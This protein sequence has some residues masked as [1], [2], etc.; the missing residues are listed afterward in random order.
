MENKPQNVFEKLDKQGEQIEDISQ[1]LEGI[2]IEDLYALAKRT[3][4]YED[5]Q[6]AQ[7]YYNHI[8]LLKPLDWEAPLY[9]SLCN[10]KGSH[11][12]DFWEYGLVQASKVLVSTINY[13]NGLSL[14]LDEKN[15]EMSKCLEIIEDFMIVT[16]NM[17]FKNKDIFDVHIPDFVSRLE[18]FFLNVY[19][20]TLSIELES[21]I[22]FRVIIS[23][24]CLDLIQS[25]KEI[26]PDLTKE[27]YLKL[28]EIANKKY[29]IDYDAIITHQIE[30]SKE[31]SND[32][33]NE[34]MLKGTKLF[35]YKDKVIAKRNFK[36]N[37]IV[38]MIL[39]IISISGMVVSFIGEWYWLF[40]FVFSFVYGLLLITKALTEK[41]TIKCSSLLC[42]N[43][44]KNRLTSDGNVVEDDMFNFMRLI[45][46]IVLYLVL[47]VDV[48]MSII[49]LSSSDQIKLKIPFVIIAALNIISFVISL[50]GVNEHHSRFEGNYSYYYNGKYYK[51]DK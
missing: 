3:W 23:D 24:E 8:S 22:S 27:E 48:F 11:Q 46:F 34:I 49:V 41:K 7:K 14:S 39:T 20:K 5:Y 40:A 35:E 37:F 38:G 17:Y 44:V 29:D 31:M 45:T 18:S 50:K 32:E 2:S 15:K 42:C 36:R 16:K 13:I 47:F 1:R 30:S 6:T 43:R 19:N 9:A 25:T 51:I 33:K 26:S 12:V 21:L 4:D 28:V 10:F